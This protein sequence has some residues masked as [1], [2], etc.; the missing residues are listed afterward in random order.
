MS[1]R[2]LVVCPSWVGDVVMATPALRLI[3][4]RN[5][6]AFIGALVRP[7]LSC[8]LEGSGLIDEFHI[9]RPTGVLGPKRVAWNLRPRQYDSAI[10]LT[11]S[12]STALIARIAGISERFGYIRDARGSLLTRGIRPDRE[13]RDW[14]ITPAIDYYWRLATAYLDENDGEPAAPDSQT[15]SLST[16]PSQDAMASEIL[17]AAGVQDQRYA[18]LIPGASKQAKRWPPD[19]FALIADHLVRNLGVQVLISGSPAESEIVEQ[20]L[21]HARQPVHSL[22][23]LGGDLGSLMAIIRRSALVV[24]NDTGPRHIAAAF[25]VPTVAL[26]GPTDHRWTTL[27]G[28]PSQ[29][30]ILADPT[31]PESESAN[32]H[33]ERCSIDHIDVHRVITA[34]DSL[35][36]R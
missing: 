28:V 34:V 8:L 31:L 25:G 17:T 24:C 33:P 1:R 6:G 30:L 16:T 9:D 11:N 19:R 15:V 12:F 7:G 29:Q 4:E 18:V 36:A 32:D 13:G 21:T 23:G 10:L 20:V 27:K 14:K 26:F 2:I 22:I 3:R 5:A 35:L